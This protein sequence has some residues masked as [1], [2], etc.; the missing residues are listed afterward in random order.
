MIH[1]VIMSNVEQNT[2]WNACLV[3]QISVYQ[4]TKLA[5][6]PITAVLEN[7]SSKKTFIY[8]IIQFSNSLIHIIQRAM[9]E[10]AI[11]V[12]AAFNFF[13]NETQNAFFSSRENRDTLLQ[14]NLDEWYSN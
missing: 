13:R 7:L 2:Q 10:S 12:E 1:D 3:C 11:Q 9:E 6:T 14:W 8:C 4:C 5:V